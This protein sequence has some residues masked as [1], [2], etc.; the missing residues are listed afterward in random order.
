MKKDQMDLLLDLRLMKPRYFP[1][2]CT[3]IEIYHVPTLK[4]NT[5]QPL[6]EFEISTFPSASIYNV[7]L[8]PPI[9]FRFPAFTDMSS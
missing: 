3:L 6:L 2:P 4:I 9:F 5:K 1:F 8:K 7:Y